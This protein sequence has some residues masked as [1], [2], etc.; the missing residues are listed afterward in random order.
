MSK[1]IK[2]TTVTYLTV[3]PIAAQQ[4]RMNPPVDA[5]HTIEANISTPQGVIAIL[6]RACYDCHSNAT[7]WR[8]YS[9]L[10]ILSSIISRDVERARRTLNFS[11]WSDRAGLKP[12]LAAS[13]LMASC[14]LV[15][16]RKMPKAPYPFFHATARLSE[17][18]KNQFCEWSK[19]EANE[20]GGAAAQGGGWQ[21]IRLRPAKLLRVRA[22]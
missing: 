16:A 22:M 1:W 7:H 13:T 11:E 4:P 3:L 14:A 10:P 2:I 17:E 20:A 19:T 12:A 15:Q 6:R 18:D 21:L 9:R 8:W 5:L